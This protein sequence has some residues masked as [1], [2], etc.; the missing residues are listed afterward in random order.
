MTKSNIVAIQLDREAGAR[1]CFSNYV[2]SVAFNLT[3]SKQMIAGLE[4]VRDYWIDAR[5]LSTLANE[6]HKYPRLLQASHTYTI[7]QSLTRRGLIYHVPRPG[8]I[9]SMDS[10][11]AYKLTKA[12]QLVCQL[13]V[14]AGL[15]MSRS[16]VR[17][18]KRA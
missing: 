6:K 4:M 9:E 16:D 2:Q 15:M 14:E 12:G 3:L 8:P 1:E 10:H 17:Q 18:K 13:L 5:V 7:V 11:Q